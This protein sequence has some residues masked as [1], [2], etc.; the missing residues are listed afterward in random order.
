MHTAVGFKGSKLTLSTAFPSLS[1]SLSLSH[2]HESQ[3]AQRECRT[4]F[5]RQAHPTRLDRN[6]PQLRYLAKGRFSNV[7]V[8]GPRLPCVTSKT[9]RMQVCWLLFMRC[10]SE[11]S[12]PVQK[13]RGSGPQHLRNSSWIVSIR[14]SMPRPHQDNVGSNVAM[15]MHLR[16]LKS[17]VA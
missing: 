5:L 13:P 2:T 3:E 1:L 6:R 10:P 8:A 14:R 4:C 11:S 16:K 15:S 9:A 7:L 12:L 17:S